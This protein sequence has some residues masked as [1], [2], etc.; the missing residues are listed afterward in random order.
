MADDEAPGGDEITDGSDWSY[1]LLK[2]ERIQADEI[3]DDGQDIFEATFQVDGPNANAEIEIIVS[4][5]VDEANV[6][7]I[8]LHTLHVSM[9]ELARA[10]ENRRIAARDVDELAGG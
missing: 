3:D 1:R 8:A 6:V 10:T 7:S 5:Y 2:L 4:D 9:R